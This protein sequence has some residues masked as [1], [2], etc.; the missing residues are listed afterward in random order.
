M[1]G[2]WLSFFNML[3]LIICVLRF[4]PIINK[5][6]YTFTNIQPVI[7]DIMFILIMVLFFVFFLIDILYFVKRVYDNNLVDMY[8]SL[9]SSKYCRETIIYLICWIILLTLI[10][11]F[12]K[13]NVQRSLDILAAFFIFW[14]IQCI[15][16]IGLKNNNN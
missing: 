16:I 7:L 1:I 15:W 11:I 9:F 10:F 14:N 3:L 5:Y 2:K 6:L 8:K 12:I 13:P 4:E